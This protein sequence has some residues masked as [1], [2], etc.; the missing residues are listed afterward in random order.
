MPQSKTSEMSFEELWQSVVDHPVQPIETGADEEGIVAADALVAWLRQ[1][2]DACLADKLISET[3]H[4]ELQK[5]SDA[6]ARILGGVPAD[7]LRAKLSALGDPG[8]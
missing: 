4:A 3:D 5:C 6:Y 8:S 2:A 7:A 1:I